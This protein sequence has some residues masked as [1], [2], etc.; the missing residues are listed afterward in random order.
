[1][2]GDGFECVIDV[3][4]GEIESASSD[5]IVPPFAALP[6]PRPRAP[7][8]LGLRP[9]CAFSRFSS[10]SRLALAPVLDYQQL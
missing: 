2:K 9:L 6:H 8:S 4:H 10:R 1:M 3:L 7:A 5:E